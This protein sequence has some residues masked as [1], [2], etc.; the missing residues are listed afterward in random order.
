MTLPN[1]LVIGAQKA[2]TTSL[3]RLLN[4]HPDVYV[5]RNK[6][7]MFFSHDS[8]YARGMAWYEDFFSRAGKAAAVGEGSTSYAALCLHPLCPQ[9]VAQHLPDARL[10][11][12]TRHPVERAVSAWIHYMHEDRPMPRDVDRAIREVEQLLG[13]SRYMVHV[14]AYEHHYPSDRMHVLFFEDFCRDPVGEI[15]RCLRFLGVDDSFRPEDPAR[16]WNSSESKRRSTEW[17]R[18]LKASPLVRRVARAVPG[19]GRDL[20]SAA[21]SRRI[22]RPVVSPDTLEWIEREI[23]EETRAFLVRFGKSP[24][25][26]PFARRTRP[27]PTR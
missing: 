12:M 23:G 7:P 5:S 15:Q 11:Y 8:N 13:L 16:R 6:E 21:L 17:L 1:F 9:R 20:L 26:W 10:V 22:R 3:C 14:E 19:F 18:A 24:D 4:Q 2:G 27:D 25:F